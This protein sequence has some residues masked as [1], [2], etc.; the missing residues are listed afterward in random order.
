MG[1]SAS[2]AFQFYPDDFLGSSKVAV[3]TPTEIGV[4]VLLLC[5]D[6][7]GHGISYNPKLLAR[8]CRMSEADFVEAWEV[9]GP[10]FET[11]EDGK[12]YNPRLIRE[13]EK[14]AA[15]SAKQ[16]AASDA[17]WESHRISHGNAT[18]IPAVSSP[19]PTP[20]PATTNGRKRSYPQTPEPFR[21]DPFCKKCGGGMGKAHESATRLT[22]IHREDCPDAQVL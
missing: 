3:M 16:K 19:F 22:I 20:A 12:L 17:R 9:V 6:W 5:M 1:K 15:Y 18:G 2:P 4:Y 14:Q 8:Y 11:G 10:C 21:T 13:R 7:N